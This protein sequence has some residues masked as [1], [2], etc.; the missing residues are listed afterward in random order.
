MKKPLTI[1]SLIILQGCSPTPPNENAEKM[2]QQCFDNGMTPSYFSNYG[3][4][5][6]NCL[7]EDE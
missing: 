1:I 6:I 4:I 2:M 3:Q 7:A 5:D